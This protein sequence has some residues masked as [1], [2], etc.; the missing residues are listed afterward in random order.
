MACFSLNFTDNYA[1][2]SHTQRRYI[3]RG[4]KRTD[5]ITFASRI[6]ANEYTANRYIYTYIRYD[7]CKRFAAMD[8]NKMQSLRHNPFIINNRGCTN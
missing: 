8:F 6:G 7:P 5:I 1:R 2:H 3:V 4:Y